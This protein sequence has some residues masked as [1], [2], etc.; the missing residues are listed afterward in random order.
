MTDIMR[1]STRLTQK[2]FCSVFLSEKQISF[3]YTE[4]FKENIRL[5]NL[6]RKI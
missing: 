5:Q 1:Y 4:F 6:S 3:K 2:K